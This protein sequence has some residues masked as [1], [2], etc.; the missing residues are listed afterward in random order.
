MPTKKNQNPKTSVPKNSKKASKAKKTDPILVVVEPVVPDPVPVEQPVVDQPVV[1]QSVKV[2]PVVD[3]YDVEFAAITSALKDAL[4][5]VKDLTTKVNQLEK[6][7]KRDY[8]VM[9]KKMRGRVKRAHDPNKKPSGFAKPGSVS[10]E[11]SKFIG[12]EKDELISRTQVTKR[13]TAYCQEHSLQSDSD[14]RNINPDAALSKL[15]R[16]DSKKDDPL[17]F[18]NLQRFMKIHYPDNKNGG[19]IP[20]NA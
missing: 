1:D 12:H 6:R 10:T 9:E 4:S 13:I 11:L 16:Y 18:F 2:E 3:S 20:A 19:A 7:V 17:T 15:L 14:K 8:K 5:L